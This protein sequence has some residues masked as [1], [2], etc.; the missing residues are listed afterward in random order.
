MSLASHQSIDVSKR[1]GFGLYVYNHSKC[2]QIAQ[3]RSVDNYQETVFAQ[4]TGNVPVFFLD[5]TA[6]RQIERLDVR[7]GSQ[8][9]KLIS[10]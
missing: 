2:T 4:Q 9:Q 7:N 8:P 3:T 5:I 1:I 6:N 10:M